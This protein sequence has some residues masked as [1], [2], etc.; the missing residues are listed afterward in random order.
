MSRV[1]RAG[2]GTKRP[3]RIDQGLWTRRAALAVAAALAGPVLGAC[4]GGGTGTAGGPIKPEGGN[5]QF[6]VWNPSATVNPIYE[7]V[8]KD[9][10]AQT[11]VGVEALQSA[12]GNYLEK[13]QAL[14]SA[15]E[16]FDLVGS[17]PTVMVPIAAGGLARELDTF[18]SRDRAF[19]LQDINKGVIEGGRWKAKLYTLPLYAN[20]TVLGYNRTIF[21]RGGVKYPDDTWTY[22]SIL[23]AATKLTKVTGAAET[24][25][26][27]FDFSPGSNDVFQF[28]WGYGGQPF[29]KDEDPTRSTM[30]AAPALEALTWLADLVLKHRVVARFDQPRPAMAT[31]RLAML[32]LPATAVGSLGPQAQFPWDIVVFPR[33]KA[34]RSHNGGGVG[35]GISPTSQRPDA[36]WTYLSFLC[37]AP[38]QRRFVQAQRGAP[39]HKELEKDYLA[40]PA[41]PANRKA[42]IDMVPF[43]KALPKS[44]KVA[45]AYTVYTDLFNGKF[46]AREACQ[47]IDEQ[48]NPILTAK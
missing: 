3:Q 16:R 45:N 10:T 2:I 37:G 40:L 39:V 28:V 9:F 42:V 12:S 7:A 11:G 14:V 29:D 32:Q 19:K 5:V 31:G 17:S 18:M 25:V 13:L 41:S 35:Y 15:G 20:A 33:G 22:E 6:L 24:D 4:A 23:A 21:D 8:M 47:K 27:G 30:S 48:V 46:A 44:P 1:L 34:G 26:Y 36:A 43:L 38:G